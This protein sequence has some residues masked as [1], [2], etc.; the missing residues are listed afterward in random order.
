[1]TRSGLVKRLWR[2]C[3]DLCERDVYV[4]VISIQHATALALLG[5]KRV[6]I[7]DFGVFDAQS[8]A[9]TYGS[10]SENGPHLPGT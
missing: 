10:K 1:M 5:G 3:P 4:S 9:I 2:R 8:S 7:R 6:E